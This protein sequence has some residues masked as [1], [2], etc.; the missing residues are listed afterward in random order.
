MNDMIHWSLRDG[1]GI[2][3]AG[4]DGRKATGEDGCRA[5]VLVTS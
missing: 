4:T 5:A 2:F 1:I 3:D